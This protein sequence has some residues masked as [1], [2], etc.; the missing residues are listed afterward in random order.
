MI[1]IK[2]KLRICA[3]RSK[4]ELPILNVQGI[5]MKKTNLLSA[6]LV[7]S[8][9][10]ISGCQSLDNILTDTDLRQESSQDVVVNP[11]PRTQIKA[12]T[13]SSKPKSSIPASPL[14]TP[15]RETKTQPT[16]VSPST[17]QPTK[18][19]NVVPNVAPSLGE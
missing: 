6:T 1:Q 13:T 15:S 9:M 11:V 18:G 2:F 17:A 7:L 5:I 8:S 12:E 16:L 19:Q 10:M 14:S 4:V 3:I